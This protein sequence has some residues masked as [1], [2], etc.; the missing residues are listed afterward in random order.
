[1]ST[2]YVVEPLTLEKHRL[3]EFL[4]EDHELT[5]FLQNRALA[6][7]TA[8]ASACFVLVPKADPDRIAGFYTLSAATISLGKLPPEMTSRLPQYPNLPATLL[9]RLA[10]DQSWRGEGLGDLLLMSAL[11]RA[12]G[13]TG[14]VG[15]VAVVTDPKNAKTAD[16]YRRHGF[17]ELGSGKRMFLPMAEIAACLGEAEAG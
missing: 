4:C 9:G 12:L 3:A 14:S 15:A 2:L 7:M 5:E 1:M 13:S 11:S 16:F 6:E 8:R 10:R 17:R